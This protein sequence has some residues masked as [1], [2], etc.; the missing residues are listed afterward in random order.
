M[1]GMHLQLVQPLN[2]SSTSISLSC[3]L[4]EEVMTA[5]EQALVL[6][7]VWQ[8]FVNSAIG[9]EIIAAH[10]GIASITVSY[11]CQWS[12]LHGDPTQQQA[13]PLSGYHTLRQ[14]AIL[15]PGC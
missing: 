7:T 4:H 5:G 1:A 13:A 11:G 3:G 10:S 14:T 15:T 2:L 12:Y 6:D 8:N 9:T